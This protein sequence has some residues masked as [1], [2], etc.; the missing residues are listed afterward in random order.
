M[1]IF[2]AYKSLAVSSKRGIL[3][4]APKEGSLSS[5][6]NKIIYIIAHFLIYITARDASLTPER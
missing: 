4:N 6:L 1:H 2:W 5:Q 3:G